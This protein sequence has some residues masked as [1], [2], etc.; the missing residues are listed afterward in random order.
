MN[1]Q[2]YELHEKEDIYIND[3]LKVFRY[4]KKNLNFENEVIKKL[5][6]DIFSDIKYHYFEYN[7]KLIIKYI[8]EN[9]IDT[10]EF[11]STIVK[12]MRL[13]TWEGTNNIQILKAFEKIIIKL[14]IKY[15]N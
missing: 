3:Y 12:L 6:L 1:K 5:K 8:K 15:S 4:D 13:S 9:N 11:R 14:Y 7:I 10:K 2:I